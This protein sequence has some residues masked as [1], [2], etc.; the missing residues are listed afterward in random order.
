MAPYPFTVRRDIV[1][2]CIAIHNY[3]RRTIV[4]D[5]FFEQFDG[6]Y[7]MHQTPNVTANLPFI[8][9]G[10]QA[11]ADQTFMINLQD[12]IAN[13]LNNYE[14]LPIESSAQLHLQA[15]SYTTTGFGLHVWV[16]EMQRAA[17]QQWKVV[18]EN[19]KGI[20]VPNV[21]QCSLGVVTY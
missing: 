19:V 7:V 9:G 18:E 6:D 10:A 4:T 11:R 1:I 13:E 14:P 5:D 2:A 15:R 3:L 17:R 21:D 12:Q 20:V 8:G 16:R